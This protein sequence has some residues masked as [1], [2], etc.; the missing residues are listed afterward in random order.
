MNN[1]TLILVNEWY[2]YRVAGIGVG[3]EDALIQAREWGFIENE[4]CNIEEYILSRKAYFAFMDQHIDCIYFV[5]NEK[6]LSVYEYRDYR[7]F[8]DGKNLVME[9]E[10]E[11]DFRE[12]DS[13]IID[14]YV[15][16]K[17]LPKINNPYYYAIICG[18]FE[19]N[20][21]IFTAEELLKVIKPKMIESWVEDGSVVKLVTYLPCLKVKEGVF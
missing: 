20:S 17:V 9:D 5:C 13:E 18:D 6:S 11:N 7:F 14:D 12:I 19:H 3:H 2:D 1:Y 8:S 16:V 4:L 10:V 21:E 15:D